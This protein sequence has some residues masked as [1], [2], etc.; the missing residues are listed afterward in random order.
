MRFSSRWWLAAFFLSIS[1]GAFSKERDDYQKLHEKAINRPRRVI[2]NNDGNEPVYLCKEVSAEELLKQR[3][4][5][6]VGSHVDSIF[7]CTW[8]SGFGVFTHDTKVGQVFDTQ[9]AMFTNNLVRKFLD[10]GIDPL[11]VMTDF[12]RK[13]NIEI[14]WS[15]RM[16]DTHDGSSAAYGPVMFRANKLKLEHPEYLIGSKEKRP[17]YGA[18]SAVDYGVPEIR[19]LAYKFCEEVCQNYDVDG[20]E[21]DFFRHAFL[22]KASSRGESCGETELNQLTDL[23]R[24]IRAMIERQGRKR[25]RPILLAIRVPDSVEYCKLIGIDLERWLANGFVDLLIVGGYTQ[26][27][28]WEYSVKLGHKYGVKVYPSLDESRVA[29]EAARKLRTTP[30]TFRGRAMN[31]WS[32]GADGVYMFNFFNPHSSLWRELGDPKILQQLDRNYFASVRGMGSMPIP[33]KNFIRV[34]V[35]NPK[36][37]VEIETNASKKITFY[38][39]E[40][41]R[42]VGRKAF[43]KTEMLLQFRPPLQP[44]NLEVKLNGRSLPK[45]E[46][47]DDWLRFILKGK[48]LRQG[49]NTLEIKS[50]AMKTVFVTDLY[51]TTTLS[52]L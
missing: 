22:F 32:A 23:I 4:S 27:N 30:E 42:G 16:N 52:K 6:L 1:L 9:E 35:L 43:P 48:D 36:N 3:T 26:I 51:V 2:F 10:K 18:W 28:L 33:H 44:A 14:F 50:A 11:R 20:I 24:Q 45:P 47:S 5:P 12:G 19:E 31:V 21:L 41:F 8:S 40:D 37:P 7:Y 38:V 17:K 46:L 29:D 39:G 13:N 25:N 49:N 15:M 34:P